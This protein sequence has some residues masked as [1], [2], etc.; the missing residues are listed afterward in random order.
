M[1]K[2]I[3]LVEDEE[4]LRMALEDRLRRNGY[5]V[6]CA[7]D[8]ET[9]FQKASSLPFDLMIVDVMLPGKSGVDLC[10]DVR[11]A[12]LEMPVLMLSAR[13]GTEDVIAGFRAGA[14]AYV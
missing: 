11:L 4:G 7:R 13:C 2:H 1:E 10:R 5:A 12:G 14:D 8:G 6:E 9:G 3:L